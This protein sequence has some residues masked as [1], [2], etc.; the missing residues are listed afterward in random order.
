MNMP[1]RKEIQGAVF[2]EIPD[3]LLIEIIFRDNDFKLTAGLLA[4]CLQDKPEIFKCLVIGDDDGKSHSKLDDRIR[5]A[6]FK[7]RIQGHKIPIY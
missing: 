4:E 6:S 2:M 3:R 1:D 5:S 7:F